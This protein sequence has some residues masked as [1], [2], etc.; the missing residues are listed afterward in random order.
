VLEL[1]VNESGTPE[2]LEGRPLTIVAGKGFDDEQLVGLQEPVMVLGK[3][4]CEEVLS[5]VRGSYR[6]VDELNTCG[7]CD[8]ILNIALRR[9]KVNTFALS[10]VSPPKVA[11]LL[12]LGKMKGLRYTLPR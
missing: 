10:P 4:A 2:E 11:F 6:V 5:R 3:C 7:H 12:L 8:N 9:L 1:V